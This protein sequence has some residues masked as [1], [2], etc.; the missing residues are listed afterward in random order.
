M[1]RSE[2]GVGEK[3]SQSEEQ[4]SLSGAE[5]ESLSAASTTWYPACRVSPAKSGM[6]GWQMLMGCGWMADQREHLQQPFSRMTQLLPHFF[7]CIWCAGHFY[8]YQQTRPK[9]VK[10]S[11]LQWMHEAWLAVSVRSYESDDETWT[12][13]YLKERWQTMD[14]IQAYYE[15]RMT[16]FRSLWLHQV[17]VFLTT[18]MRALPAPEDWSVPLASDLI[19]FLSCIH[20]L[21]GSSF[22]CPFHT[23]LQANSQTWSALWFEWMTLQCGGGEAG[24]REATLAYEVSVATLP[25]SPLPVAGV[26]SFA[27]HG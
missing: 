20:V 11:S 10:M 3:Q 23:G 18:L 16:R 25:L 7:M 17:L 9:P 26:M 21:L 22:A 8:R 6:S 14:E 12:E 24:R 2:P 19:E 1:N 4:K 15:K 13:L 27:N 5:Q